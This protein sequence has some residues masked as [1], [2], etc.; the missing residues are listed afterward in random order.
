MRRP[1]QK[2]ADDVIVSDPDAAMQRTR[3]ATRHILSVPKASNGRQPHPKKSK[4]K[5]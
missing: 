5:K 3:E 2:T 4:P 1:N